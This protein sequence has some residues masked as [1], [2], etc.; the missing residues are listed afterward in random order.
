MQRGN[1][2]LNFFQKKKTKAAAA[3]A[4]RRAGPTFTLKAAQRPVV[5]VWDAETPSDRASELRRWPLIDG[6]IGQLIVPQNKRDLMKVMCCASCSLLIPVS[7]GASD[8]SLTC[9]LVRVLW[10][11]GERREHALSDC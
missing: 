5:L 11:L 10:R 7:N 3:A 2:T 1:K 6:A 4:A 9:A 8:R